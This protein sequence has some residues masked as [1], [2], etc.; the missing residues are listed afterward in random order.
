[1]H[2]LFNLLPV[3]CA[4]AYAMSAFLLVTFARAGYRYRIWVSLAA[5]STISILLVAAIIKLL[6]LP[7]TSVLDVALAVLLLALIRK[8]NGNLAA[9]WRL[10]K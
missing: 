4:V 3:V 7:P 8:T 2:W 5:S 10:L 1:M 6:Y 9:L